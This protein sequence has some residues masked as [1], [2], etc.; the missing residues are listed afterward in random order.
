MNRPMLILTLFAT[1]GLGA[2]DRP[3]VVN[4]PAAA[5]GAPGPAGPQGETGYQGSKGDSGETGDAGK[6]GEGSTVIVLPPAEPAQ[7]PAN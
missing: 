6:S 7:E 4:V 2:C 5:P 1:L 3:N